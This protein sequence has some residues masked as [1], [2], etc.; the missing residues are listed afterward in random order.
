MQR[1][2]DDTEIPVERVAK[3]EKLPPIMTRCVDPSETRWRADRGGPVPCP[4]CIAYE[5]ETRTGCHFLEVP[6]V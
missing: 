3:E 1:G 6:H 5:P 2:F 4:R